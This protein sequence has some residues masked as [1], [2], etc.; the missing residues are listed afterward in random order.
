MNLV[1]YGRWL[2]GLVK[3]AAIFFLVYA[4]YCLYEGRRDRASFAFTVSGA[5]LAYWVMRW[6]QEWYESRN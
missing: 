1:A 3:L 4:G 5:L 6:W 2:M